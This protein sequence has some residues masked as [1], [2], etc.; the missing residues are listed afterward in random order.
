MTIFRLVASELRRI[1]SRFWMVIAAVSI[2]LIPSIY[3]GAYLFSNIDPY[4][5]LKNVPVALV[6]QDQ[7]VVVNSQTMKLGEQLIDNLLAKPDF[8]WITTDRSDAM[9][10]VITGKY[11]F[12]IAIPENFSK[13]VSALAQ[14]DPKTATLELLTNDA[15][16]FFDH[17]IATEATATIMLLLNGQVSAQV[18]D[19][20]LNGFAQIHSK[21]KEAADGADLLAEN[22]DTAKAGV[23]KLEAGVNQLSD[24][25]VQLDNGISQLVQGAGQLQDG[26][27][28]LQS[29]IADMPDLTKSLA[30]GADQ[31][32]DANKQ[33]SDLA[34]QVTKV[35]DQIN[36]LFD[37]KMSDQIAFVNSLPDSKL[38]NDLL[39]FLNDTKNLADSVDKQVDSIDSQLDQ[40]AS[41]ARQVSDGARQLADASGQ[42]VSGVDQLVDGSN[43][44]DTGLK[45]LQDGFK[46]L[47][48]QLPQ[49]ETGV[50]QLDSGIGE[51]AAGAKELAQGL[52]GGQSEVPDLTS[53]QREAIA[54]VVASPVF[55]KDVDASVKQSYVAGLAPFFIGLSL[56]IG[57]YVLFVLVRG[58]SNRA[59]VA[60][61]PAWKVA[62]S[63]WLSVMCFASVQVLLLFSVVNLLGVHPVH[64]LPTLLYMFLIS[65]TYVVI[66]Q[67]FIVPLDK[68]G[69][70]IGL[71]LLVF[72]LT[73]SGGTFPWQTM[74]ESFQTL[75]KI[76]PM[77]YAVDGLR[78]LMYGGSMEIA[79]RDVGILG[80]FLV[81]FGVFVWIM[82]HFEKQWTS[83]RIRPL[84]KTL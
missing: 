30:D 65:M 34:N 19:Q 14:F 23:D 56:W 61:T 50:R 20:M 16:S 46:Q 63:G 40:L 26:L 4:G 84:V 55:F 2:C 3:S 74:P 78:Q 41:G 76:M 70:F 52:K 15:N 25:A 77:S 11:G 18:V 71:L 54:K 27:K 39:K 37:Q 35:T 69:M 42:L 21:L 43:R 49:F 24:G 80:G 6:N 82:V 83:A 28:Q 72:Q 31:V 36:T 58:A 9:D 75:H 48:D 57:G 13:E 12:G 51:L 73:S 33:I 68:I 81:V 1:F 10:G 17:Q 29:S 5:N 8:D 38:K 59:L 44:L 47:L 22:L 53:S 79:W 62:L 7:P 66:L 32:A 60:N 67:L 64:Q 45:Q